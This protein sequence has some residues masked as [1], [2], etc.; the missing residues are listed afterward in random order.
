MVMRVGGLATGMDIEE[1]VNKLMEAERIPLN[2]LEQQKQTLEW[3]RDAFRDINRTLLDLDNMML[4]M[5]LTRTYNSKIVTSSQ[6][7]AITATASSSAANDSFNINVA[8]LATNEMHVGD[9]INI[10]LDDEMTG[11]AIGTHT[12]STYDEDGNVQHH[13]LVVDEGDTLNDVLKKITN[14]DNNV[15]AFFDESAN[16]VVLET[17]RTGVYNKEGAEIEFESGSF[18]TDVLNL[19]EEGR[20]AAQNAVFTYNNNLEITSRDN[21][22]TLNNVTMNFNDVT[23]GNASISVTSDTESAFDNIVHFV[24]KYNELI[25]NMNGSLTE[26]R[27]RD[28]PPLTE[29]QKAE[30]T[31]EQIKQWEE[32]AQSGMLRGD[33]TIRDGMY[34]I[35]SS[36]Q[37]LTENDGQYNLLSQIGITTTRNYL[38][39]GR[40]EIDESKL[41]TALQDNP[42]EVYKLFAHNEDGAESGLIYKLDNALD[43]TKAKIENQAGKSTHTL[44]NYS[45]GRR[46][47]EINGRIEDFGR[48]LQQVETRYWNQF[49]QMEKMIGQLNQQS[50][51]LFSMFNDA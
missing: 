19:S 40:L 33:A 16:R 29:E 46:M 32:K 39:G 44:E 8:Q 15:R 50:N 1:M 4:D 28:F 47:K 26:E 9:S 38:D 10:K 6:E 11:S 12:F 24:D 35:R 17:T 41:R 51:Q 45:L 36:L 2:K 22:Y 49:T 48:R 42:D 13:E 18:F 25:D 27:F 21:S 3:K 30:M 23:E 7:G 5:K 43:Q 37:S 20:S 34:A 14:D 31:D